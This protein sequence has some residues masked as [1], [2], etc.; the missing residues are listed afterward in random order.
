MSGGMRTR[1]L[2]TAGV[3]GVLAALA[4]CTTDGM[5]LGG[6]AAMF[7][8]EPADGVQGDPI[9]ASMG[10]ALFQEKCGACHDDSGLGMGTG[11][12]S[13]RYEGDLALLENRNN[14]TPEFV[15]LVVRNG[16]GNMPRFS[17]AEVSD[18]QLAAI[19]GYLSHDTSGED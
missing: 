12:L 11:L 3:A 18:A 1:T 6:D 10:G 9:A 16:V 7:T 15:A 14:L 4:A 2:I 5:G 13:R 19:G 17:R 8:P